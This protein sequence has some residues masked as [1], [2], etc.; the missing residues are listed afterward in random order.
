V[1]LGSKAVHG[2]HKCHNGVCITFDSDNFVEV[3]LWP[4]DG[5]RNV[6]HNKDVR[7]AGIKNVNTDF[8]NE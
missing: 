5:K 7:Q 6:G 4:E 3:H 8:I 1:K 2:S